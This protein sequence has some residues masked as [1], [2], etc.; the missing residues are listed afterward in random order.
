MEKQFQ[1]IVLSNAGDFL[2]EDEEQLHKE[3]KGVEIENPWIITENETA[4]QIQ[5]EEVFIPYQSIEN[6][7]Y[8]DFTQET[9]E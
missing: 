8:G 3:Q 5:A 9:A 7:Q 1:A 6:I 2:I 4:Q